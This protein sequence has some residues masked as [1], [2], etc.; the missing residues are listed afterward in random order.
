LLRVQ[1]PD[2]FDISHS[3]KCGCHIHIQ[4]HL[5]EKVDA[6]CSILGLGVDLALWGLRDEVPSFLEVKEFFEEAVF[7]L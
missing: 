2:K 5:D 1:L 7:K 6:A 4:L 3:S